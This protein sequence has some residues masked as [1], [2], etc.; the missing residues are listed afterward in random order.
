VPAGAARA[1]VA[2]V[3]RPVAYRPG[4]EARCA[5]TLGDNAAVSTAARYAAL[6]AAATAEAQ[7]GRI[8]DAL[9][10]L[11]DAIALAPQRAEAWHNLGV[12][13]ATRTPAEAALAAF[14]EAARLRRDW[15]EPLYAAGHLHFLRGDYAAAQ[16]AFEAA[17]ARDPDHVAASVDLAQALLRRQRYSLALPHLVHARA[18][19]P[20]DEAIW[21][22]TRGVL[23]VLR[24]DEEALADFLAF[25]RT[26]P[27]T[28]RVRIAALASARR[29]GDAAFEARA[30][31]DVLA[32]EFVPGESALLAE[33]LAQAQY[34]D[35]APPA[36][37]ALYDRYDALMRAELAARREAPIALPLRSIQD[38]RMVV[39]YLSADFRG[40]VM[41]ELLAPVVESHDR[42][43]FR[44]C[45][46][47][48][49]PAGNADATTD[50]FR[51][52]ADA[53]IDL[54][55]VDDE[56]AARAIAAVGVDVLVDLMGHSAFAR[57]GILA[58]RP[59]HRIVTHLGYHGGVG[60]AS[61]DWKMTD[62][63]ADRPDGAFALRERLLPLDVCV[64][65]L[66]AYAP[67]P[68]HYT[69]AGLGIAAEAAVIAAFVGVQKLSPRCV[70]LWRRVLDAVPGATLLFSPLRDDDRIALTR[71]LTRLGVD[72]S[73]IAFV[74][75]EPE[76]RAARH[77]LCDFALDTLPY[78]G[79]DTTAAALAAGVPVVTRIGERHA[80]RVA[81]SILTHAGLPELVA[82][83]DEA[84]VALAIRLA[85]DGAWR[86]VLG[87]KVRE[88]FSQPGLTDPARY[89]AALERAYARALSEPPRNP[90]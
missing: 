43:R 10:R 27:R 42:A 46:F 6:L 76:W 86:A 45:L 36:L 66:R 34:F 5:A 20:G 30:L 23:L 83:D 21:W 52:A 58:R 35:V 19:A 17:L 15:A 55:D 33:A 8:D 61:V 69:R 16:G 50:R 18:L 32:H 37:T 56:A 72:A 77:A 29:L 40:H 24:R 31:D 2:P 47:S 62:R 57:P 88:A 13:E 63:I 85:T 54:A 48:L 38:P 82:H 67:P 79:G 26:A 25:E 39:G 14:A 1:A 71:R 78:T 28:S 41:G 9:A 12:L 84:Y 22:L 64:L 80:E 73:R 3:T 70:A 81:A 59:A 53:F 65:P 4:R 75:Y 68:V 89:A 60:L 11:H 90:A 49:A 7:A 51:A 87:A 44:V 74:P